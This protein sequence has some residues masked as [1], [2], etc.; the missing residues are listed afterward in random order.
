[1]DAEYC[2]LQNKITELQNKLTLS[3]LYKNQLKSDIQ[4]IVKP[5]DIELKNTKLIVMLN[6]I[7][8]CVLIYLIYVFFK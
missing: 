1:M 7:S 3:D 6:F 2:H 8:I 5:V 4:D